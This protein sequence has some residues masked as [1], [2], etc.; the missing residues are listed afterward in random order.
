MKS[1][2]PG[3]SWALLG[4][5]GRSWAL[6]G[7]PGCYWALLGAPAVSRRTRMENS[8][9]ESNKERRIRQTTADL[10]AMERN[11]EPYTFLVRLLARL[12]GCL[13]FGC[14][15]WLVCFATCVCLRVCART[16]RH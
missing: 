9:D 3:R 1:V 14:F 10:P 11:A 4:V 16:L 15:V 13:L 8:E 6:S 5:P 12:L 2:T 7:T